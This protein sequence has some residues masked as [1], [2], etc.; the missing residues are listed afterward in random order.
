MLAKAEGNSWCS[1]AG[2]TGWVLPQGRAGEG[3]G[4][5]PEMWCRRSLVPALACAGVRL[6]RNGTGQQ[7]D[8]A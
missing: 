7:E 5:G 8:T 4:G 6:V 1:K 3:S 2:E